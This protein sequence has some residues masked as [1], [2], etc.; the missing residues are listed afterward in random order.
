MCYHD[1][2]GN[3]G[4]HACSI[5]M[6]C[7]NLGCGRLMCDDHEAKRNCWPG[8][9]QWGMNAHVCIEHEKIVLRRLRGC[10]IGIIITIIFSIGL[11]LGIRAA[12][13]QFGGREDEE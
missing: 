7:K 3:L 10:F 6:C 12:L 2:C 5:H 1:Q 4:V 8:A 9:N 11:N 13:G